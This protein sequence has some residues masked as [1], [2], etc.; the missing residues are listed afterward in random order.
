MKKWLLCIMIFFISGFAKLCAES[1]IV[2]KR[3]DKSGVVLST[4]VS[5]TLPVMLEKLFQEFAL[6]PEKIKVD[7]S[8]TGIP[9]VKEVRGHNPETVL[10]LL[11]LRHDLTLVS[12]QDRHLIIS[13]KDAWRHRPFRKILNSPVFLEKILRELSQV[14]QIALHFDSDKIQGRKVQRNLNYSSIEDAIFDLASHQNAVVVYYPRLHVLEWTQD[15]P[16]VTKSVVL[17]SASQKQVQS[18]LTEIR[19]ELE[20]IRLVHDSYPTEK[21]LI[22]RG[23]E[24]S[25]VLTVHLIEQWESGLQ[26]V[27]SADVEPFPAH[28]R[29]NLKV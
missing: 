25:V 9:E 29:L 16:L 18:F 19:K 6:Y 5:A 2:W 3:T 10:S 14:G 8:V 1:G 11:L 12:Q 26:K 4:A 17:S 24:E 13:R 23:S 22:L 28:L 27:S 15:P 21:L 20:E 7:S